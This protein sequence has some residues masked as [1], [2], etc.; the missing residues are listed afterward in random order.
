MQTIYCYLLC[1]VR[2]GGIKG[3]DSLN[4]VALFN[5][6]EYEPYHFL[7]LHYF[8]H[9]NSWS[10]HQT[11]PL[12]LIAVDVSIYISYCKRISQQGS[13]EH[14]C[15]VSL[16]NCDFSKFPFFFFSLETEVSLLMNSQQLE[17]NI[18]Q[19]AGAAPLEGTFCQHLQTQRVVGAPRPSWQKMWDC[20]GTAASQ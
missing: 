14:S 1:S 4:C 5:F 13:I 17:H 18:V 10:N 11:C 9:C 15:A 20:L 8:Y 12:H 6:R 2:M 7:S 19:G 16:M 3:C